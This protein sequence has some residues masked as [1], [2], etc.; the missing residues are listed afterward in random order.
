MVKLREESKRT[1]APDQLG[2]YIKVSRPSV[3][4]LMATIVA[5]LVAVAAWF[6]AGTVHE[7]VSGTCMASE[8]SVVVYVPL[9]KSSEVHVGDAVMLASDG[10]EIQGTVVSIGDTP[11]AKSTIEEACGVSDL[12][13]FSQDSWGIALSVDASVGPGSYSARIVTASHRP[14]KLLLGLD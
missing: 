11:L 3:W 6:F 13:A 4:M 10:A 5:L 8:D 9:T 12:P 7:S 14:I 2:G 1:L